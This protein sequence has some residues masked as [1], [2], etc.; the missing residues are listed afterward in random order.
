MAESRISRR[1]LLGN[2]VAG[3]VGLPLLSADLASRA[4]AAAP[5][6]GADEAG[7]NGNSTFRDLQTRLADFKNVKDF[8]AIGDGVADDTASIQAA[9]TAAGIGGTVIIPAGTYLLSSKLVGSVNQQILGAGQNNTILRRFGDYGDTLYFP[10]AGCATIRGIWF[11]H[12]TMPDVGFTTLT[13]LANSGSHINFGNAQGAMIE[14]CWLWRMPTQIN[15]QQ[16][17]LI[18]VRHC[19]MQG[20]WN[21]YDAGGREGIAGIFVGSASYIQLVNITGCYFGGSNSGAKTVGFT[22][23]DNGTQNVSFAGTNAGNKYGIWVHG[24]E[25]LTIDNCYLGGNTQNCI[26][27]NQARI[28][29]QVRITNNFF[30]GAGVRSSTLHIQPQAD[31]Q[32]PVMVN[33]SHNCFNGELMA[34]HSIE[35]CNPLGSQ[36]TMVNFQITGNNFGN[37]LGSC[38]F[39]RNV[40]GGII[41][42]N[43]IAAYNSRNLT[44]GG[45]VNYCAGVYLDSAVSVKVDNNIVGGAVNSAAPSSYCHQGVVFAGTQVNVTENGTVHNGTGTA[46]TTKGRIRDRTVID[47]S[48]TNYTMNGNEECLVIKNTVASSIQ[49]TPPTNPPVGYSFTLKDGQGNAAAKPL[50]FIGTVDGVALPVFATNYISRKLLW[51]GSEWNLIGS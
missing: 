29:S 1:N 40:Q 45:D 37:D 42:D 13:K 44:L 19:N 14:D 18:T 34:Y 39:L 6:H 33:I 47:T 20:C 17:S 50:Q 22:I 48:S 43:M 36:P 35:S 27:L 38:I 41:S 4:L 16:G 26:F 30:D 49:I 8:G 12:G 23:S 32:Y 24:C 21:D 3:G 10:N 25:G 46:G 9:I 5:L 7:K 51:N 11:Y 2:A 15:L 31:G 28:T